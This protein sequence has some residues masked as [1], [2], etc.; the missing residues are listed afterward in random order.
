MKWLLIVYVCA[1]CP[2]LQMDGFETEEECKKV[3][4]KEYQELKMGGWARCV[5]SDLWN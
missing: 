2:A 5:L 4:T 1:T 3:I